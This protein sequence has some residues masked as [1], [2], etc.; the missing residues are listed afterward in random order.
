MGT[1]FVHF[2]SRSPPPA[3]PSLFGSACP[4]L[5]RYGRTCFASS[6]GPYKQ[7]TRLLQNQLFRPRRS[8]SPGRKMRYL[9]HFCPV[10][11]VPCFAFL[12]SVFGRLLHCPF[13]FG[14][15]SSLYMVLTSLLGWRSF[16]PWLFPL[17]PGLCFRSFALL[18]T[19]LLR[20]V[21]CG[22]FNF[23]FRD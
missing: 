2:S 10:F 17:T 1:C 11:C 20:V 14:S 9:L 12:A 19:L 5:S 6:P 13:L 3:F 15:L 21:L 7:T 23:G 8:P 16:A 4:A 22:C 18:S